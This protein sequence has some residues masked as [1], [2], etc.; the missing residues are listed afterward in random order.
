LTARAPGGPSR[1]AGSPTRTAWTR[2]GVGAILIVLA[3]ALAFRLIIAYSYPGTGL[4]FDLASFKAWA[5]NLA[6]QGLHGFYERPFFHDYTPGYLYVLYVLGLVSNATGIALDHLIKLPAIFADVAIGWLVWSMATELGANRRVAL[7][8]A[9]LFVANPVSWFD[10]VTWGQVDSFGVVFLLLGL[11]NL[12]RDRPERAA[13]WTVIAALIKPQLAILIP[14]VAVVTI[15]RALWPARPSFDPDLDPGDGLLGRLRGWEA[16]TDHPIRMVTTGLIALLTAFVLCAP[17]GLSLVEFRDGGLRSGLL[18]QIFSTASGYPYV[19]VN[20]YNPWALAELNGIGI[21]RNGGWICDA[22]IA[23][24]IPGGPTCDTAFQIGPIPAL[25]VGAAL[26]L[27]A[28]VVISA[29]VARRP[30]RLTILVGVTMLAV[31]F[32]ILPTRVHERY[33]YP[34]FALGA[35]LAAISRRWLVAYVVLSVATFLNMYVVVTTLYPG[36]PAV[37]DWLGIGEWIRSSTGVTIIA[38]ANLAAAIWAFLRLRPSAIASLEGEL[39]GRDDEPEPDELSAGGEETPGWRRVTSGTAGPVGAVVARSMN[40]TPPI[41]WGPAD[42]RAARGPGDASLASSASLAAADD[43]SIP[44]WSDRRSFAEVGL[45]GWL[46]DRMNDRPLR[47]DRSRALHDE[48][49]G[50]IDRLDIWFLVV[51]VVASLGLRV[52]RLSEPYQMHFDE[53]YHARTATEFLQDWRYG[54]SHDIYEWT[55]PHLAKYAM[56]GGLV[57]WGDDRVSAT[58]DLGVPVRDALVE[59]RR[60][61]QI[62]PDGRAGDHLHI[63]TGSELRTYDLRSR[64]LLFATPVPNAIALAIDPAGQR[65]FIGTTDGQILS[66]DLH[67]LDGVRSLAASAP[68][69]PPQAFGRVDGSIRQLYATD[70]GGTLFVATA[71]NRLVTLDGTSAEVVGTTTL[72]G[73]AA[74]APGGTGPALTTQAGPVKDPAAAAKVIVGVLGGD[75]ATYESRLRSTAQS[76]VVAGFS[77][78]AKRADL[79]AA[80]ADGRLAGL[81]VAD[82]PRVAIATAQGV[83]FVSATTGT[84]VTSVTLDGGARGLVLVTNVDDPKLY[85][86]TGSPAGNTDGAK[87]GVAVIVVGGDAAKN[88]PVLQRTIPMPA[89]GTRVAYDD[90]TQMVHVVGPTPGADG[91]TIYVIETHAN[92]VFADARLPFEPAA[93]GI[94]VAKSYPTDDRQQILAFSGDGAAASVEI[95]KHAFAWRLPGVI[96]GALMAG[97]LYLLTRILFRRREV[98]VLVGI[99]ALADGMFFV[100]SRIGM[101]DAYVGLGI[102]AAYTLFAAI[103]TGAWRWR[104]AFWVA[105]PAIGVFL[106]LA[107]ASKWV[108][109][110]AIGGIGILVLARSAL[111]RLALIAGLIAVTAVLGHLALVVPAGGGLGN[112]PF[113]AIMVGLT[114]VAAIVNVLH[115]IAWSDDEMRFAVG[116]P[117]ALGA[118]VALVAIGLGKAGTQILQV[119]GAAAAAATAAPSAAGSVAP[120]ATGSTAAALALTPIHVAI[121]LVALSLV[122]YIA[123]MLAGRA[124][125]GPVARPPDPSDAAALLPPATPS[126]SESWLRPGALLGLPIAWMVICLL[127]IP[128][129]LY[130]A[131]YIPWAFVEGHQI[132]AGWPPGHDGQT[133]IDLTRQMY[134]YHNNLTAGHAAASPWWAWP[135]DL[136]P[137][138]FYQEGFAGSTTAAVYDAGNLV[139]WW[140]GVPAL[141]F[142]AWQAYARRSLGLALIAIAFA[143]QWVSWARIDRAAFQYHYYTSLP[144]VIMA[145]AYFA[146]ELWHGT[147]RRIWTLARVTAAVAVLG[148]GLLWLFDRPFCGLVGVE[149][150]VPN[151]AACPPLI[152]E[153]VLTAQTLALGVVVLVS[154]V[155]FV[156]LL[157]SLNPTSFDESPIR[158]LVPLG[159]TAAAALVGMFLVRLVPP[160]PLVALSTIPVEPVVVVVALL[161]LSLLALFVATARDAR[162]FVVGIVTAVVAWFLVVYPNI[163]ALPLPSVIANAYQGILPTYLYAFQFPSNRTAVVTG[164]KLIDPVAAI[165]AVALTMLCIVLAYSAWVWRIAIAERAA[166]DADVAAGLAPEGP[167]P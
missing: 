72:S 22:L 10:S 71:D 97:L 16:R 58:S 129:A 47:A 13:V 134:D 107:L 43:P 48:P 19:S 65:L 124:G 92:A 17:F 6:S 20:G 81:A 23:N 62:V 116:A 120:V 94:D 121:A 127:V 135:F 148:P 125:F 118:I 100:Q 128:V 161:P 82:M 40:P 162:R 54:L 139:I 36:N 122:V 68:V 99:F 165:L 73:I 144:F 11:R 119:G 83:A 37:T 56:A 35:I 133:L 104:G 95:G 160:T 87:G 30:D 4:E 137:V 163:S 149:R 159:I 61:D 7:V 39:E 45:I 85:A 8:A 38:L 131:S 143:C 24:P 136:K 112:L 80:I 15:R 46:K 28:F 91:W 69:G 151:S 66:L 77:G 25:F 145:L 156:R 27:T 117:A 1:G 32:F 79:A 123:F 114:A 12:W 152:P 110:Y 157:V 101:N 50:R 70:D 41:A 130:V 113:V 75:A 109:L 105:M 60:D 138:W 31:A 106:G 2:D 55:H 108:A 142:A 44:T 140:L 78:D 86:S 89:Q 59:V 3:A 9:G 98:A 115:P 21:A 154:I 93:W 26:L 146:A 18:Q 51:I 57:A 74:F 29:R 126:P 84:V 164:T 103:W 52:F 155:V 153:F 14:V 67:S 5:A 141:A 42:G 34:F 166:D 96:A 53:V 102:V 49:T 33:L 90:A 111:G 76:T 167:A 158:Q 63:V 64:A 150:A 147:S 88:G 132:I